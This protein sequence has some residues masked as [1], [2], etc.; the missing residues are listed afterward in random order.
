MMRR[1]AAV[2]TSAAPNP[3]RDVIFQA[4]GGGR[5]SGDVGENGM[6][7]PKLGSNLVDGTRF[8]CCKVAKRRKC[9]V[10]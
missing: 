5:I 1:G 9:K 4:K 3:R 10:T 2:L 6:N 8:S 7:D